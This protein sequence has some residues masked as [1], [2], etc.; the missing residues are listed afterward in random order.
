[1]VLLPAALVGH[2][3]GYRRL[4]VHTF[5]VGHLASEPDCFLKECALGRWP[6]RRWF[7]LAPRAR[8]ANPALLEQWA[9][10][11]TVIQHP[12]ACALLGAMTWRGLMRQEV[13]QYMNRTGGSQRVYQVY[14][15][16]GDRPPIAVLNHDE[17]EWGERELRRLGVPEGA[18]FACV[19]VREPGFGIDYER[20]HQY[21]NADP[22]ALLPAIAEIRRRGGWVIRMG[23]ASMTPLP[24]TDGLIDY[25][26]SASKSPRLD[27]FL[28]ARARCFLG[29]TS[30]LFLVSSA[31]GVPCALANMVPLASMAPGRH[32][33]SIPK[34]L[35]SSA[36]GRLLTFQEIF[37]GGLA[38]SMQAAAYADAGIVLRENSSDEIL[39]LALDMLDRLDAAQRGARDPLLENPLAKRFHALLQPGDYAFGAASSVSPRFLVRHRAL[40]EDTLPL[41]ADAA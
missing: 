5:V 35:W 1:V 18:W 30:G 19:H 14:R 9:R 32:D 28:C 37:A 10:H 6:A 23:D 25:A 26:L 22:R 21:R 36:K 38:N 7:L 29:N 24:A 12:V 4:A 16:W 39:D 41:A 17:I 11:L 8:V 3:L 27:V 20:I 31:F 13:D 40:I 34:L 33:L 2:L 15:D